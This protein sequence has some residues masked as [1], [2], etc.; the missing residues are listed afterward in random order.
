LERLQLTASRSSSVVQLWSS[1]PPPGSKSHYKNNNHA[2]FI[3]YVQYFSGK[4][5]C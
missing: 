1:K 2:V 5:K 4:V 3:A